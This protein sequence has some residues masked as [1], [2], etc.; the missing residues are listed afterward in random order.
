MCVIIITH[1][2]FEE[3]LCQNNLKSSVNRS[4]LVCKKCRSL[5]SNKNSKGA[6]CEIWAHQ[7]GR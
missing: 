2:S 3:F 6:K 7:T 4:F 1:V 5:I